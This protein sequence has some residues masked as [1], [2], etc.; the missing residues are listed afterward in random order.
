MTHMAKVTSVTTCRQELPGRPR[1]DIVRLSYLGM[2]FGTET[3]VGK[4]QVG[5]EV[6][7]EVTR[8]DENG[9]PLFIQVVH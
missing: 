9:Y 3:P 4:L 7:V 8:R 2:T 1:I 5:Q 6:T